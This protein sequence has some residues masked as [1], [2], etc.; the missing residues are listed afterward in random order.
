MCRSTPASAIHVRAVCR[1]PWRTR[2]GCPSSV[3]GASQPVA[4]LKVG[5][6]A[7]AGTKG[8][9]KERRTQGSMIGTVLRRRPLGLLRHQTAVTWVRLPVDVNQSSVQIDVTNAEAR[10]RT[11]PEGGRRKDGHYVA[12]RLVLAGLHYAGNQLVKDG[13]IEQCEITGRVRFGVAG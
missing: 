13:E 6:H 10:H 3:T 7:A 5:D 2:P 4:S 9:P 1:R 12:P 11:D 8:Q